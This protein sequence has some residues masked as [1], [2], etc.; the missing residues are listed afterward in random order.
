MIN[1][2]RQ[3]KALRISHGRLVVICSAEWSKL[4][5]LKVQ[6]QTLSKR[7]SNIPSQCVPVTPGFLQEG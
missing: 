5:S 4:R 1:L 7:L 2:T 6:Q 3:A